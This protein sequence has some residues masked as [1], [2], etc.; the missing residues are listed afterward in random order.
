MTKGTRFAIPTETLRNLSITFPD[1]RIA[2]TAWLTDPNRKLNP[3]TIVL[4]DHD[5]CNYVNL[6]IKQFIR[7]RKLA[8]QQ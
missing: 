3:T 4:F 6:K 5:E 2:L 8:Q 1:D 7:L